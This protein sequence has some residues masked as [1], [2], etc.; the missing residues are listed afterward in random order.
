M[1]YMSDKYKAIIVDFDRTLLRTDKTISELTLDVLNDQKNSGMKLFAATARPERAIT[2][3]C[4]QIQFDAVTT[5]NGARTI[6][7]DAV[8]ETSIDTKSVMK[9]LD[10]L[11][12]VKGNVISM[13]TGSGIYSNVDIPLWEPEVVD[14]LRTIAGKEKVYKILVSHP[15]KNADDIKI[16]LPDDVYSTIAEHKLLQIM[17]GNAT[18]WNGVKRMLD[19]FGI[20]PEQAIYFGDDNDDI[21]CIRYCG[22]GAAVSNAIESVREIADIVIESNDD[23][24]VAKFM[25]NKHLT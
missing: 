7:S 1:E 10:Q 5:L 9:A 22:L 16:D 14:D 24:G 8:Y 2:G 12:D 11:Y 19:A 6:T 25:K 13:E 3:Y 18:K 15:D 20:S 4:E 23:D 17:A 21:E